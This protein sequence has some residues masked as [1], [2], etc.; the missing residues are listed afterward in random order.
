[1]PSKWL[2]KMSKNNFWIL[3]KNGLFFIKSNKN[4]NKRVHKINEDFQFPN[5]IFD[6]DIIFKR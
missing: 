5:N 4:F 6:A 3:G 2:K 1:M